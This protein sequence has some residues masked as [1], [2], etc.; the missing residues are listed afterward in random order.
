[1]LFRTLIDKFRGDRGETEFMAI[2]KITVELSDEE[3]DILQQLAEQDN[4]TPNEALKRAIAQVGYLR[5][6]TMAGKDILVGEVKRGKIV[7]SQVTGVK[8]G[9]L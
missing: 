5:Q 2:H 9:E 1:M 7:G 6:Q 3:L 4:V 8:F